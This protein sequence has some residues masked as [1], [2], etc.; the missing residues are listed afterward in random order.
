[1]YFFPQTSTTSNYINLSSFKNINKCPQ[2]FIFSPVFTTWCQNRSKIEASWNLSC[3]EEDKKQGSS[4][5]NISDRPRNS[6][7]QV[8]ITDRVTTLTKIIL[9]N[10]GSLSMNLT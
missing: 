5:K 8:L 4:V 1:M 10:A 2:N 7:L 6:K 3:S 9:E